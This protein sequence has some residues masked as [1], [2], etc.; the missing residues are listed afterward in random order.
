VWLRTGPDRVEMEVVDN[1][2]GFDPGAVAQD[3]GIGLD[4]MRERA[5][6]LGGTVAIQAAPGEGTRVRASIAVHGNPQV[7]EAFK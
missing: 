7:R 1:G 5:E 2:R 3:R 6:K 4:S